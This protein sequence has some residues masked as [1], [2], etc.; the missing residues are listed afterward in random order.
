MKSDK[1][2]SVLIYYKIFIIFLCF[3]FAFMS[4]YPK[5]IE[6]FQNTISSL[7]GIENVNSRI[8]NLEVIKGED[9]RFVNFSHLP[10]ATL[11]RTEGGKV[12]EFLVQFEFTIDRSEESL[13]SLEFISWFLKDEARSG[14]PLQLRSFALPPQIAGNIQLRTTLK[15]HID[16]FIN[17]APET[18]QP[19]LDEIAELNKSISLF[20]KLY[21]IPI[22]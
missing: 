1:N 22:K 12:N 9:L 18:L 7:K 17:D 10:I 6:A 11:L 4:S 15:F 14:N 20:I 2:G 16:F 19:I 5:E 21:S 8:D 3:N 13:V